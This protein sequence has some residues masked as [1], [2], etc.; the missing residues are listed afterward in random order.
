MY[1]GIASAQV[2]S[3]CPNIIGL[4]TSI[5][6]KVHQQSEAVAALGDDRRCSAG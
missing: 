3:R 4:V 2:F 5:T 1:W 6:M